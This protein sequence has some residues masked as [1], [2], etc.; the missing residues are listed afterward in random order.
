M[1][2]P[3]YLI[4]AFLQF[5]AIADG[6]EVWFGLN[7]FVNTLLALFIAQMPIVGTV[8]GIN[9]AVNVWNWS[10]LSAF[11]LYFGPLLITM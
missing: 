1:L 7:G 10:W 6:L 8:V 5:F 2:F 11:L 9:A 3:I 4:L